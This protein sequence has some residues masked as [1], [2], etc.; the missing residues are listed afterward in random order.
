V[1]AIDSERPV[2]VDHRNQDVK[3]GCDLVGKNSDLMAA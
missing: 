2:F 1:L 3:S